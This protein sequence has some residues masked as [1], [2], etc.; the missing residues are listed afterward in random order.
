M[1]AGAK[2][3]LANAGSGPGA[4][5]APR[6]AA[7]GAAP[8]PGGS[9][10][11]VPDYRIVILGAAPTVSGELPPAMIRVGSGGRTLD[12]LLEA[13]RA[14]PGAEVEFVTGFM[15]SEV[16]KHYPGIRF[17]HNPNW[18]STG[19]VR[20]L[21]VAPLEARIATFVCYSDVVFRPDTVAR[22]GGGAADLTVAVDRQWRVRY[23]G[24]SAEE[25]QSAEK[26]VFDGSR[27][28]RMSKSIDV[29]EAEAEFAGLFAMSGRTARRL[30][31]VL[32][33]SMFSDRAGIPDVVAFLIEHGVAAETVDVDGQ[34][35]EL[36]APQDLAHFVLGTKAESL[37]RLRP[38]VRA[39]V[40]GDLVRFSHDEWRTTRAAVLDR[41]RAAFP[42]GRVIARSS[43]IA[44][45]SW[46]ESA[47]GAHLSVL[48][49]PVDDPS[50][51]AKAIEDVFASYRSANGGNQ[52][53]VQAMLTD[54]RMSG[55]VM[56]RTH[57]QHAP[58]HVLNFDD[59]TART[60]TVTSGGGRELKTLFLHR[61]ERLDPSAGNL[62]RVMEAVHELESLVGHD[63]LDIEFAVTGDG[64][65]RILQVRPIA[66]RHIGH[67]SDAVVA[68]GLREAKRQFA[69][70]QSPPPGV[71]G[72]RTSL[73]VMTDWN[74]AEIVGT[75]PSRLAFSLYRH[76]IT[77]STWARQR[78]EYG[79]RDVRPTNLLVDLLGHP[80]VDVR[81]DFNSFIPADLS[82]DLARR[83]V[84]AHL[85]HL[86][87]N[88][89]LH[90]KVEFDI[91]F[92]CWSFDF[93]A[94]ARRLRDAGLSEADVNALEA[95]LLR[96]TRAGLA[97]ARTD[98]DLLR[99]CAVRCEAISAASLPPLER[100]FLHLEN[101]R[102]HGALVFSHLARAGFV[103]MTLLRSLESAGVVP[104]E[105][106][107]AFLASIRTVSTAM[108]DD[109]RA[110]AEGRTS[111]EDFVR[112]YGHLRPGTYDI[113]SP[114]YDS[115]PEEFLRPAV[116]EA[117]RKPAR[118]V[119]FA[120]REP[121]RR[122]LED[123]LARSGLGVDAAG[124]E[125]F[126]R[127]ATEGREYGKFVFTRDLSAALEEIAEFGEDV[128]VPRADLAH[129]TLP[130][131]TALRAASFESPSVALRDLV[132]RGRE[133][134][135]LQQS[136][137]MPDQ[138]FRTEDIT[139]FEYRRNVPNYVTQKVVRAPV[140][141]LDA[142]SSPDM[143]LAGRIALIPSADPGFDWIFARGIAG[144]V[145][146]YGGVNSHMAIRMAEFQLPGATGVGEL[147]F[148]QLAAGS[149]LELDC[150]ARKIRVVV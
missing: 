69:A 17:H 37:E 18:Q 66:T 56:T 41:I 127:L 35:A 20:S 96:L 81:T 82:D 84:D 124:L 114:R 54:V 87:R 65:V 119:A 23:D 118:D 31:G 103:A 77:D 9:S 107:E 129:V 27:V 8:R 15:A 7:P 50:A 133:F 120:W 16:M 117:S 112:T 146:M 44:E 11:H 43:A 68:L 67:A 108:Q 40:V 45:D 21:A 98:F 100:A 76:I 42:A 93:A 140:V 125:A 109:A 25:L 71:V 86:A 79:Y 104:A 5:D 63:S 36:N 83:L 90:D 12:W 135:R 64:V 4:A 74:P 60:D 6:T 105:E 32:S 148:E 92:T 128:F 145:T 10:G 122:R 13:F 14:L 113:C 30:S 116:A 62:A 75:K 49:V 149:V 141:R 33:S 132:R 85:D 48:D 53:L 101:A 70:L 51:L 89:E 143:D 97:R 106:K 26:V 34:W 111:F 91:L 52:V 130:E 59:S 94:G 55:V 46:L 126:L 150:A 47:A 99:A 131:L 144:L 142:S 73:S 57:A 1:S 134:T 3:S 61:D 95:S 24:R 2:Q 88:P 147:V 19:P 137:C 29:A 121:T 80:Y 138:V 139:R 39:G 102:E 72:A 110:V 123:A 136:V 38:L 28:R 78:A 22:M 115:A 58:W